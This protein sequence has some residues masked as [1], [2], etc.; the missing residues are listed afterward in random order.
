MPKRHNRRKPKS[1]SPLLAEMPDLSV[2]CFCL[3]N[4]L[5]LC[6]DIGQIDDH[7]IVLDVGEVN[8]NKDEGHSDNPNTVNNSFRT[9]GYASN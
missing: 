3:L 8:L 7:A 4:K 1:I 5:C 6:F 2:E 9:N